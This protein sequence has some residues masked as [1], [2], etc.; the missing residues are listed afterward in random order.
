MLLSAF[1]C[2]L[3]KIRTIVN[4][5]LIVKI[6]A[7]LL[8]NSSINVFRSNYIYYATFLIFNGF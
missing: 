6:V 3:S 4:V 5:Y 2:G 7:V 8:I 1:G